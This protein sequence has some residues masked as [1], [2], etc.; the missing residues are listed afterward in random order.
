MKLQYDKVIASRAFTDP[1]RSVN[2]NYLLIDK[3]VK[4]IENSIKTKQ[5]EKTFEFAKKVERL[6]ALSPLKTLAR[7]Y[8]FAEKDG[9]IIN[10]SK[11]LNKNDEIELEFFDG[12]KNAIIKEWWIWLIKD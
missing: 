5:K 10:S 12:I 8:C 11:L 7:G 2:D 4:S 6:D 9:Q 1:L 3:Y